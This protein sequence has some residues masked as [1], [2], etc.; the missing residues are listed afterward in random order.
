[1]IASVNNKI[2]HKWFWLRPPNI[3]QGRSIDDTQE[4]GEENK[5][6]DCGGVKVVAV[7]AGG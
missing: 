7:V 4:K 2:D 3:G 6:I 1:M 5:N